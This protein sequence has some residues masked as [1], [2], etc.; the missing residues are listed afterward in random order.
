MGVRSRL[1]QPRRLQ[2]L[3]MLFAQPAPLL[4]SDLPG[5]DVGLNWRN[6]A[7]AVQWIVFAGFVAFFWTRFRGELGERPR[8]QETTR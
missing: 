2:R 3:G 1:R 6:A 4:V 5:A 8:Q 7:Y